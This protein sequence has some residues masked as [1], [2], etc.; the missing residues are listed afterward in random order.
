[1]NIYINNNTGVPIVK[2]VKNYFEMSY[3]NFIDLLFYDISN[4]SITD[5]YNKSNICIYGIQTTSNT[6]IDNTKINILLCVE[7]CSVDRKHYKHYNEYYHFND[8]RI[9]I[10]IYNDISN[11]IKTE[12]YL[13]IP[14][15]YLYIDQFI[16][17]EKILSFKE[18][19][20]NKKKFCLFTSRNLLNDNKKNILQLLQNIDSIDY[21][22]MYNISNVS[23]YH[24]RELLEIFNK[25]KFIICFEN[26]KTD[27]YITEKI[28]NVFLSKSIPIYDGAP[29]INNYI[30]KNSYISYE[31]NKIINKIKLLS[32]NEKLYNMYISSNKISEKYNNENWTKLFKTFIN[33][34]NI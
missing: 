24:S 13:A 12:K 4:T 33:E 26:S 31:Y 18:T 16:R 28:F 15:I 29:N 14:F 2:N 9:D 32:S 10:Y 17:I 25:Y 6:I 20:F 21:I 11:I 19:P 22:S 30:N 8:N 1:M 34:N 5:N 7:N 23:C 3:N 27:G